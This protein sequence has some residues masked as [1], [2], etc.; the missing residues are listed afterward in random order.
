VRDHRKL[1]AFQLADEL[2]LSVY[3]VT[4][5]FPADERFGLSSQLRRAAVS[6]GANIVE[7]SAR[8]SK[9]DYVRFLGIAFASA[10]ELHYELSIAARLGYFS[11]NQYEQLDLLAS[12]TC[13]ALT[14]L[15]KA[16]R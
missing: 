14:G 7:G 4:K 10:R 13:K 15:I 6:I 2:V 16:L 12:R 8:E 11:D 1:E 3:A 9:A 5:K